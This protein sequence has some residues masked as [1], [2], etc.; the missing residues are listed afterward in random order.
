MDLIENCIEDEIAHLD[1]IGYITVMEDSDALA[2]EIQSFLRNER[3][4]VF[5]AKR[6]AECVEFLEMGCKIFLLD[7]NMGEG[8]ENEGLSAL[9]SLKKVNSTCFVAIITSNPAYR[10]K[11]AAFGC[12]AFLQKTAQ[13]RELGDSILLIL[14]RMMLARLTE[15]PLG[16]T[17]RPPTVEIYK[18]VESLL[19]EHS[20]L[21]ERYQ[22]LLAKQQTSGLGATDEELLKGLEKEIADVER[23]ESEQFEMHFA[24]SR[25]GRLEAALT[26]VE[27][28]LAEWRRR[29]GPV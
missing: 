18:R 27:T 2:E 21:Y 6:E 28:L 24:A 1:A 10:Q 8:L 17:Q 22:Q 4:I 11:A 12:D 13:F 3:F 25:P 5:R 15:L 16:L 7:V 9:R 20:L 19:P 29:A 23:L 14:D 26:T